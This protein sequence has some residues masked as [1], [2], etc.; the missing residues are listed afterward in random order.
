M[1]AQSSKCALV[2]TLIYDKQSVHLPDIYVPLRTQMLMRRGSGGSNFIELETDDMIRLLNDER[3]PKTTERRTFAGVLSAPAGAGKT[4]FMR[5]LYIKLAASSDSRIPVFLDARELNRIPTVDFVGILVTAFRIAGQELSREQA[6]DGLK[7]GIFTVLMDGFDEVRVSYERH[8]AK[9]LDEAAE[10]F[11]S[12]SPPSLG[13]PERPP[14]Y[15]QLLSGL[16]ASSV[17]P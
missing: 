3:D 6:F 9:V 11:Q 14:A 17:K 8:Y 12:L 10:H 5:N 4:F 2:R 13:T 16:R 7:S 15:I 1:I